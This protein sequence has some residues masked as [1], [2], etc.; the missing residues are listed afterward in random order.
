MAVMEDLPVEL[1]AQI[2]LFTSQSGYDER[3][4]AS[5][6][7]Q[8]KSLVS[9]GA[10]S[11]HWRHITLSTPALW[12]YI[13]IHWSD[14]SRPLTSVLLRVQAHFERSGAASLDLSIHFRPSR[15]SEAPRI[16]WLTISPQLQRCRS[17][18]IKG[19]ARDLAK[20]I[21]PIA[22][23]LNDLKTFHFSA[24]NPSLPCEQLFIGEG[25]APKLSHLELSNIMLAHMPIAPIIHLT[26]MHR[27]LKS[28]SYVLASLE[29]FPQLE[30]VVLQFGW[31]DDDPSLRP[32][33][34]PNLKSLFLY[35]SHLS[36]YLLTPRLE[37]LGCWSYEGKVDVV[38][39]PPLQ[40]LSVQ[41]PARSGLES[42]ESSPSL[43]DVRTLDVTQCWVVDSLLDLLQSPLE[44][45]TLPTFPRLEKLRIYNS[46]LPSGS[47]A[48]FYQRLLQVLETRPQL[49][50]EIDDTSL[51]KLTAAE[52]FKLAN[53][54]T[55]RLSEVGADTL[56]G[57]W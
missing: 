50:M 9:I 37:R 22:N 34:L 42:W 19:V 49:F 1:I 3:G 18:F 26:L 15:S 4:S 39:L 38:S 12:R 57:F 41:N 11:S 16:M 8:L 54:S 21:L 45:N 5:H 30:H 14:W 13:G 55:G 24:L 28:W 7:G 48:Y 47:H 35:D 6:R 23:P 40:H 51:S 2:F 43:D 29:P 27:D 25:V 52:W 53:E 33:I 36:C 56:E 10:V 17:I 46:S 20:F 32:L 44:G 31:Q